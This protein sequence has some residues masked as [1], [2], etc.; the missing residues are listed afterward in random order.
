MKDIFQS[1]MYFIIITQKEKDENSHFD[2]AS[3]I[4]HTVH[5]H[6]VSSFIK[7]F[8]LISRDDARYHAHLLYVMN[9]PFDRIKGFKFI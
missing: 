3:L 5:I 7:Y 8:S 1:L 2:R 4:R 6:L 9:I